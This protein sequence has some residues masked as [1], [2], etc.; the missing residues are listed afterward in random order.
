MSHAS[1]P[2]AVG[3]NMSFRRTVVR[4]YSAPLR[5][6]HKT[7]SLF[8]ESTVYNYVADADLLAPKTWFH[9]HI[10][11][12]L[13]VYGQEHQ[14]QREDVMLGTSSNTRV[15]AFS[16]YSFQLSV[17]SRPQTM[18]YSLATATPT[19]RSTSTSLRLRRS[20]NRGASSPPPPTCQRHR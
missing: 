15:V 18:R 5:N 2:G 19:A 17:P 20:A 10:D 12:I 9:K 3:A 14:L 11:D 6:G 4:R 16:D 13:D 7:A 1:I 8:T